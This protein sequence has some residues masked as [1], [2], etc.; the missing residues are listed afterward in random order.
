M[1]GLINKKMF[2]KNFIPFFKNYKIERKR[3][4]ISTTIFDLKAEKEWIEIVNSKKLKKNKKQLMNYL[5]YSKKIKYLHHS[6][7]TYLSHP[8]RVANMAFNFSRFSNSPKNLI[9]LGLFH[10]LIETSKLTK[11]QLIQTLGKFIAEQIKILTVN[12]KKQWDKKY[13]DRYYKKINSHHKNTRIIKI[14]D[15]LDNLFII[16][17]CSSKLTR[18]R[19]IAEIENYILPMVKKDLPVLSEYF[20]GLIKQ[21]HKLGYYG[22]EKK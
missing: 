8:L 15:K 10:N 12:R 4:I 11:R 14:L 17:L 2:K 20:H 22:N 9:I 13:K 6:S 19:Y 21:S 18:N 5:D 3:R 1:I 7:K 16:G